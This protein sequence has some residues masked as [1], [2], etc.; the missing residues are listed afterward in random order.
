MS[1]VIINQIKDTQNQ[2]AKQVLQQMVGELKECMPNET[3]ETIAKVQNFIESYY[4]EL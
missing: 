1:E 4:R 3:M 2:K